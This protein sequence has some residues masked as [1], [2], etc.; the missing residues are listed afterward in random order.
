MNAARSRTS[1]IGHDG[2][3]ETEGL[4]YEANEKASS[5]VVFYPGLNTVPASK[6]IEFLI[7]NAVERVHVIHSFGW[8][9]IICGH[10]ERIPIEKGEGIFQLCKTGRAIKY[11]LAGK[12]IGSGA[13]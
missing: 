2:I 4:G 13:A 5:E 1:R 8:Q 10:I 9:M 12:V 11:V 3:F 7:Q 6:T